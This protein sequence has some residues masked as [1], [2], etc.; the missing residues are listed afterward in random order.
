[1]E[2]L[3]VGSTDSNGDA[4]SFFKFTDPQ[5]GMQ[6]PFTYGDNFSD[7]HDGIMMITTIGFLLLA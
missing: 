5:K 3:A 1:M 2:A 6:Y 7:T 4:V